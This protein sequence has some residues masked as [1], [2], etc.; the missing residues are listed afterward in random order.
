MTKQ[1]IHHHWLAEC[2]RCKRV[3]DK[4]DM[5]RLF[6]EKQRYACP[7]ILC[8]LCQSCFCALLDEWEVS[9]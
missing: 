7:T 2:A 4:R 6:I 9:M 5:Q 3:G 8:F 1:Q